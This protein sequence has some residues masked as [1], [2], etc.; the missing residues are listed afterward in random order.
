[1]AGGHLL[2]Q[3]DPGVGAAAA[4]GLLKGIGH[5]TDVITQD[6]GQGQLVRVALDA[7]PPGLQVALGVLSARAGIQFIEADSLQH[8]FDLVDATNVSNDPGVTGGQTWGAYGD[9]GAPV[10]IYGSQATEAWAGGYTGSSTVAVGV[11]DTGVDYTHPDLYLNIWL[12]QNEIPTAVRSSLTDTDGDGRISF[13]DLNNVANASFVTDVNANGRIDAGDLLN[14]V[15]WENGLDEDANGYKDDLIGWDWVNN[16]NDPMDDVGHGTHVAGIIAAQGG[17]GAGVAGVGWSTEIIVAKFIA[18]VVGGF[19]S[20]AVKALDY[21][22]VASAATGAANVV[23]TNNSWGGGGFSQAL[24]DA[25][26]RGAQADIL[27]VAAA[28]NG[29][30]DQIG[31]NNDLTPNYP[32]NLSTTASA[33]Y[34]AVI[35]VASITSTG[36]LSSF[37]NYGSASVDLAAPGSSIYSTLLG[38]GYGLMSGTSMA[39][40]FVAGAIALYAAAHPGLTAAQ[41]RADLLAAT[42]PTASL[43]GKTATGGRLDVSNLLYLASPTGVSLTGTLGDDTITGVSGVNSQSVAT[44]FDDTVSGLDGA[45]TLDGGP[46]ADR[47]IGGVGNDTIQGGSGIDTAVYAG[48]RASFSIVTNGGTT[49]V[50]D[51][52]S[53]ANLGTDSLTGVEFLQFTDQTVAVAAAAGNQTLTGSN[54]A[55]TLTGGAGNDSLVSLGGNDSLAGNGGNDSLDGGAGADTM[56]GGAGDDRYYVDNASDQVVEQPGAGIDTVQAS[57]SYTLGAELENLVLA[58]ANSNSGTGNGLNN[59]I[60]GNGGANLIQGLGGDDVITAAAGA[61]NIDGGSG[62][63]TLTGGVGNDTIQGGSGTDTAVYAGAR[64]SFSIVTNGGTTTVTDNGSGANLGTD[65]VNGVEFLQFTDQT[66]AVGAGAPVTLAASAPSNGLVEAGAT[67]AGTS[68]ASATLTPGGGTSTPTYVTTGWTSLG[69][70]LYSKAGTYGTATLNTGANSLS[71]ALDNALSATNALAGGQAV[72]DAFTV[73]VTDGTTNAAQPI[74]FALTGA[75]DA[76]LATAGSGATSQNTPLNGQVAAT[77]VDSANLTFAVAT[78]PAHGTLNLG[79]NG[80]YSYTPTSGYSGADAFTFTASDGAATSPA[81]TISLTINPAAGNQTLS[82]GIGADTLTGGAG[83]D[84]LTGLGGN[85]SLVGNGGNDSLDGG[86]GTDTLAGGA[87]DDRYYVDN[88]SDQVVEQP[89]DGIDTVQASI[90]YTLGAE[91]DNLVLATANSN[92]GTGNGLGNTINGNSGANVLQ[93]LG[94]DDLITASGGAD[95][96]NGGAGADTL[97]GGIGNDRFVY[98]LTTDSGPAARDVITDFVSGTDKIDLTAIDAVAGGSDN[99]FALVASFTGVAGQLTANFVVDH[100]EVAGDTNGDGTAEFVI[101]VVGAA[102]PV[103]TDF[104]L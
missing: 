97:T 44:I 9:F 100:Y 2:V 35:G 51:N 41:I 5:I 48:T 61:D 54:N 87:G 57:I 1:V 66:V 79:S 92:S 53:G 17:N 99:A 85:D 91:L 21:V 70:G 60:N 94:G 52:G 11:V 67:G 69:G 104:L 83:N 45:D 40:P 59:T 71:Y 72:S 4:N 55:D 49:T 16:D 10:N 73:T 15:R 96:L 18:P 8:T 39:T 93:G 88:A 90:S 77:D 32:S 62:N 19:T 64:A 58:T 76:P 13:R 86:T 95:T 82:G 65:S 78:G 6:H 27:F 23:A 42:T 31:D 37:S 68:A 47:L 89:G 103:S 38:G 14:D 26:T 22:S 24:Q 46:G 63:D 34:E 12:N 101:N 28:G 30:A 3:L 102:G 36:G 74:S 80:A 98:A 7:G 75:N 56:A 84:S 20:D 29:G 50:T 81:A 43:A 33:G 25:V